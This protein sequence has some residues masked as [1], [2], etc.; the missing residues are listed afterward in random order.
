MPVT[1]LAEIA[2]HLNMSEQPFGC[3]S[4]SWQDKQHY[5]YWLCLIL[6]QVQSLLY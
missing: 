2:L 4:G 1:L 3:V 6:Q 5:A